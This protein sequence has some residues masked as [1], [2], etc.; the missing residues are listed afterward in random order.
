MFQ[1]SKSCHDCFF[2]NRNGSTFALTKKSTPLPT[3]VFFSAEG[4]H[5]NLTAFLFPFI[6]LTMLSKYL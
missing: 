6:L 4:A 1:L 3:S 2:S 5:M